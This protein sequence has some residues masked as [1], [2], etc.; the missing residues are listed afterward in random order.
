MLRETSF[1]GEV[2]AW[3]DA[4][5]EGPV[6]YL[7]RTELLETRASFL[8][9]CGWGEPSALRARL[10]ARDRAVLEA[11]ARGDEVVLW[12]EHDLYDQLQLVDALALVASAGARF[13][14]LSS[15]VVGAFPGRPGFRGLGELTADELETLWPRR[16]EATAGL[17]ESAAAAWDAVRSATPLGL[18]QLVARD[19][20][21]L[22]FAATALRRLLEELP[23]VGDGLSQTE[24]LALAALAAGARTPLDAFV[25]V[26]EEEPA[27]FLGDTWFFRTLA[28]LGAGRNRLVA[29]ER[30]EPLP[31][32]PPN[33]D[34]GAFTGLGL[35]L[36][37]AGERVLEGAADRVALLGVD[38]WVGGTHVSTGS[39]WRWD[40]AGGTPVGA[41]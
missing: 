10:E 27:P 19:V 1:G 39:P 26:Q 31:A 3:E 37:R 24:R 33:G 25:A 12:F 17:L 18:A 14:R 38:R 2:L 6:P 15:I 4:L 5:H 13:E 35:R 8:S 41:C 29:T 16:R 20:P 11:L 30:G 28:L 22:E 34:R 21:G 9:A 36:T 40:A 7:P 23:A 32:P